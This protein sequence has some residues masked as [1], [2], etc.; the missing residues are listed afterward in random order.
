M[1]LSEKDKEDITDMITE[2]RDV[3]E[4]LT[5]DEMF[6][7]MGYVKKEEKFQND[8]DTIEYRQIIK[9]GTELRLVEK[10][11][12][13]KLVERIKELEEYISIAPNLDKMTATKY[14]SIQQ[15]AYIRGRAEEQQKAEKIINE[16][17]IPKQK[18]KEILDKAEVM[19][20]YTLPNVI[21]DLE[22]LLKEG[23]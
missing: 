9:D 16:N 10:E 20:Y 22:K 11:N 15:E 19:D 21:E 4:E 5:A 18:V 13:D 7:K 6:S 3:E 14:V 23:V 17:Y 2:S 8:I 12:Y 1:K